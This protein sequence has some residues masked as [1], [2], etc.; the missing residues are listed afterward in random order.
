MWWPRVV[1]AGLFWTRRLYWTRRLF[2]GMGRTG[3]I[4]G[5]NVV[6]PP[7][8]LRVLAH[9]NCQVFPQ[10]HDSAKVIYV[11][12]DEPAHLVDPASTFGTD[13]LRGHA[14]FGALEV[15]VR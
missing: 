1:A 12:T 7:V 6:D 15:R 5:A 11:N 2:V 9:P 10:R 8:Q 14:V 3:V 13:K 4:V